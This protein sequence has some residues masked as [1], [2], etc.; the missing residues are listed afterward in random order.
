MT[1]G[2][3]PFRVFYQRSFFMLI[4]DRPLGIFR[5]EKTIG[6]KISDE[7]HSTKQNLILVLLGIQTDYENIRVFKKSHFS[8]AFCISVQESSFQISTPKK[9]SFTIQWI[10]IL[11]W[12]I[13]AKTMKGTCIVCTHFKPSWKLMIF[14]RVTIFNWALK[15]IFREFFIVQSFPRHFFK[16]V[17]NVHYASLPLRCTFVQLVSWK[18]KAGVVGW[19]WISLMCHEI[20]PQTQRRAASLAKNG[21]DRNRQ[22]LRFTP[23]ESKFSFVYQ[24]M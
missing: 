21:I 17:S 12:C 9:V 15:L 11:H 24:M 4:F 5:A 1:L 22:L 23:A 8:I 16:R 18:A 20:K 10:T 2:L 13:W 3:S 6:K 19:S 14:F 7:F